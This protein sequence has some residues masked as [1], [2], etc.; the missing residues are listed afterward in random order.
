MIMAMLI[1]S[2]VIGMVYYIYLLL[3]HQFA[4]YQDKSA[5]INEYL[6]FQKAM[7]ADMERADAIGYP[8][9]KVLVMRQPGD[10]QSVQYDFYNNFIVRTT[11]GHRDSFSI[12][13]GGCLVTMVNDSSSLVE[14]LVL[15][16]NMAGERVSPVFKKTYSACQLMK[17][18]NNE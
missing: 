4:G 1:S 17:W 3:N 5:V 2:V 15:N 6:L 10:A 12:Q 11:A 14:K 7:Q 18:T 13:N 16:T 8:A 9:E